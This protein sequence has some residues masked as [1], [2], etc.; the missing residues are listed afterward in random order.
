[1]LRSY[2]THPEGPGGIPGLP[3]DARR[4]VGVVVPHIDL[5]RGGPIYAH[6]YR[7][8]A[9][10]SDAELFVIF[11]TAHM[12]PEEMM[13]GFNDV[14]KRFYNLPNIFRR[15]LPPPKGNYLESLF[16]MVANLKIN[17]YLRKTPNAWGTIS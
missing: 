4:L 3:K 1:M 6:A 17:K 16:Y 5:D 13:D 14:Y 12:S 9:E 2:F 11:G 15:M 7:A 10:R 8:V